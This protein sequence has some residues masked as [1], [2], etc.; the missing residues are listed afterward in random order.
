MRFRE[1]LNRIKKDKSIRIIIVSDQIQI[2]N[3]MLNVMEEA[4][5]STVGR[6]TA[7]KHQPHFQGGEYHGHADL[8]S[9]RQ[10]SW[11]ITGKRLHPNKF[12][13]DNKIPKDAKT[14]VAT[15]LGVS[16]DIF[17]EYV[18]FDEAENENVIL[19]KLMSKKENGNLL[20]SLNSL[21]NN[22]MKKS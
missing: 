2:D 10:I 21:V 20:E 14:A 17:E 15:V 19:F 12:P 3:L 4:K 16:P 13:A 7:F 11:T 18:A 6:H 8:D 5:K 22:A 1:Y 9:G